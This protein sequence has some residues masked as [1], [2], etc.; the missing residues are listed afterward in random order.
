VLEPARG[1]VLS[2]SH[3]DTYLSATRDNNSRNSNKK[4]KIGKKL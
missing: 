1:T 2:A 4:R 3:R